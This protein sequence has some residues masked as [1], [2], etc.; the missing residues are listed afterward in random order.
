MNKYNPVILSEMTP[1]EHIEKLKYLISWFIMYGDEATFKKVLLN[2]DDDYF[3]I[4]IRDMKIKGV[5]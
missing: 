2:Q 1:E 5:L 3:L 4:V